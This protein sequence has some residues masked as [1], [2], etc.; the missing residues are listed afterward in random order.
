MKVKQ[1]AAWNY[2]FE[3]LRL[4]HGNALEKVNSEYW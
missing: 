4:F 2:N 1:P 3:S